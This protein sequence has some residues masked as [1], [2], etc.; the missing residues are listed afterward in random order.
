M[1]TLRERLTAAAEK[2]DQIGEQAR[3]TLAVYDG[4]DQGWCARVAG[5]MQPGP[6]KAVM[7]LH[8]AIHA[9]EDRSSQHLQRYSQRIWEVKQWAT[10]E[11]AYVNRARVAGKPFSVTAMRDGKRHDKNSGWLIPGEWTDPLDHAEYYREAGVPMCIVAHVYN[12]LEGPREFARQMGLTLHVAPD[13]LGSWH[14]PG[15]CELV[16]YTRPRWE[17]VWPDQCKW[18]ERGVELAVRVDRVRPG[19]AHC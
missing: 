4:P 9:S 18:D 6:Q 17:V 15:F 7:L 12:G 11:F 3:R 8:A 19:L 16:A 14:Y 1:S 5:V 2:D 10:R 13:P